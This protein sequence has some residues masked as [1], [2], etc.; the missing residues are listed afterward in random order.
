MSPVDTL[1][2]LNRTSVE[3]LTTVQDG[4]VAAYKR[5]ASILPSDRIRTLPLVPLTRDYVAQA[6]EDGFALQSTVLEANKSFAVRL[7]DVALPAPAPV[8]ASAKAAK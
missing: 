5:A 6:I 7:L 1:A 8:K 2:T 3:A 4:I